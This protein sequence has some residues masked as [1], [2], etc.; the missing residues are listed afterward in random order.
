[1]WVCERFEE[2]RRRGEERSEVFYKELHILAA[3]SD[4]GS[5][6]VVFFI[7]FGVGFFFWTIRVTAR[8]V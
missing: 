7:L 1:M 2:G 3:Q 6:S 5:P 4:V 8:A